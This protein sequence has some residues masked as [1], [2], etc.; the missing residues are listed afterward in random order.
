RSYRCLVQALKLDPGSTEVNY[1]LG[2]HYLKEGQPDRAIHHLKRAI[3]GKPF[4]HKGFL[5]MGIAYKQ[6]GQMGRAAGYFRRAAGEDRGDITSH[7]HLAEVFQRAGHADKAV[8]EAEKALR[9]MRGKDMFTQMLE[10][11]TKTDR[12]SSLRPSAAVIIPLLRDAC[13]G[14][15]EDLKEWGELLSEREGLQR[16]EKQKTGR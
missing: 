15:S 12:S 4:R 8:Q 7:L 11:L 13:L 2:I 16:R 9:M 6:K 5:F 1:N 10:A 14:K 3:A